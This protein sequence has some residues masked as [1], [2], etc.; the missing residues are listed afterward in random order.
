MTAAANR[1]GCLVEPNP[2]GKRI[3]PV[4]DWELL[5]EGAISDTNICVTFLVPR[6]LTQ[7]AGAAR[8]VQHVTENGFKQSRHEPRTAM[9]SRIPPDTRVGSTTAAFRY[10]D[11]PLIELIPIQS[12][13]RLHPPGSRH[14]IPTSVMPIL[15]SL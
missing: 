8:G 12:C 1:N 10:E 13:Y 9:R 7:C 6:S 15:L 2:T 11:L 3:N 14:S 5:G 4:S